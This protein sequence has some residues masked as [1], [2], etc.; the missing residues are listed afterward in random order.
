MTESPD[1]QIFI[2][3]LNELLQEENTVSAAPT[4]HA[5][6]RMTDRKLLGYYVA[7]CEAAS[8][9]GEPLSAEGHLQA[10]ELAARGYDMSN[11]AELKSRLEK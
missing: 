10:D 5:Y 6:Q 4:T 11:L 9:T 3:K 2:D 7:S 1:V 8:M